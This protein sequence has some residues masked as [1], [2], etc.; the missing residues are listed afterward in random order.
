MKLSHPE[1][2][3]YEATDE[4]T[5][6]DGEINLKELQD[7]KEA[8]LPSNTHDDECKTFDYVNSAYLLSEGDDLLTDSAV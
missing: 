8:I 3:L 5:K 2:Y 4:E 7:S 1:K 6:S